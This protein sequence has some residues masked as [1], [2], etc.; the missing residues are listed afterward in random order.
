MS[1]WCLRP[2]YP[3]TFRRQPHLQLIAVLSFFDILY[4][5]NG[6]VIL[7]LF[8]ILSPGF[9]QFNKSYPSHL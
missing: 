7:G 3:V 2:Q 9:T 4:S 6:A 8:L 5:A 1:C